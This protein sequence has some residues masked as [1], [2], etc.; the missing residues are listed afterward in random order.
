AGL[1]GSQCLRPLGSD[2]VK[3]QMRHPRFAGRCQ[4]SRHVEMRTDTYSRWGV[5]FADVREQEQHHQRAPPRC[6]IDAPGRKILLF[7][8][9]AIC[10]G[11]T[12][13]DMPAGI[14]RIVW[15][16]KTHREG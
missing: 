2:L 15:M 13:V 16:R 1:A 9:I 7:I 14:A 5:A 12:E 11:E 8:R 6:Y 3:D 10:A 4:K